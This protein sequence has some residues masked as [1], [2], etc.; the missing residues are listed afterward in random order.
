MDNKTY[1]A[2]KI[3]CN[4]D[5]KKSRLK[6]RF[7]LISPVLACHTPRP[8]PLVPFYYQLPDKSNH[9]AINLALHTN[10]DHS[11]PP[12]WIPSDDVFDEVIF[13]VSGADRHHERL[14]RQEGKEEHYR[15]P[16]RRRIEPHCSPR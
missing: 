8:S 6:I 3:K 15:R 11:R 14:A 5:F 9:Y 10:Q 4:R 7:W 1:P 12:L 16:V 2:F 13:L